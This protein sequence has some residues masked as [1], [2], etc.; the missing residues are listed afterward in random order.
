MTI[1]GEALG[2]HAN[3]SVDFIITACLV[4]NPLAV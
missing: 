3:L 1:Q 4:F 2:P